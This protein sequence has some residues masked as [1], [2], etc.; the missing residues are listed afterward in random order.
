L[1]AG[2]VRKHRDRFGG[3]PRHGR[4]ILSVAVV[5]RLPLL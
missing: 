1:G 4:R 5:Q 2:A 3:M